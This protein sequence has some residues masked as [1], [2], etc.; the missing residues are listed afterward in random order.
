MS[1]ENLT[2]ITREEKIISGEDL[3]P[4]TRME[5]FLKKYGGGGNTSTPEGLAIKKITFTERPSLY[6]W[7]ESNYGKVIK[8]AFTFGNLLEY[9]SDVQ[10]KSTE[11]GFCYAFKQTRIIEYDWKYAIEFSLVVIAPDITVIDAEKPIGD[12]YNPDTAM[13]DE[14]WLPTGLK[15][16]LYYIDELQN[17]KTFDV[18]SEYDANGDGVAETYQFTTALPEKFNGN[19]SRVIDAVKDV[20]DENGVHQAAGFNSHYVKYDDGIIPAHVYCNDNSNN[21]LFYTVDV[22]K[23]GTYEL[24]AYLRIKDAQL[25]GATYVINEG[26][27]YEHAF[28]TT[29]GWN[30]DEE[31]FAVRDSEEL[32]GSYMSGMVVY[33][34]KGKNTIRI[35]PTAGVEKNQHFRKLYLVRV[36]DDFHNNYYSFTMDKAES[37]GLGL[38]AGARL[39]DTC[40][41]SVTFNNGAPRESDGFCRVRTS[42]G[43]LMS[44]QKIN[45]FGGQTMPKEGDSVLLICK[46][47]CVKSV[48]NGDIGRE[49]RLFD[50]YIDD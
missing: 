1:M 25:R 12:E 21:Y 39:L 43:H 35:K 13:P 6:R 26:T 32:K 36:G 34:Q 27:D 22:A 41:V 42:N 30:T 37:V 2:P 17:Y 38:G 50:A 14:Y 28:V 4:I 5:C 8:G 31:A 29:Y 19:Y 10:R 9:F 20:T 18:K 33:L 40:Y 23:E 16:E 45:L 48:V 11:D 24:A 7:L 47:G 46:L 49:A 15:T 3:Q 44:I